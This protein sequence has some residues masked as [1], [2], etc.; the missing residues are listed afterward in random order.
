MTDQGNQGNQ[1]LEAASQDTDKYEDA[2]SFVYWSGKPG[3]DYL[4]G[5]ELPSGTNGDLECE[6]WRFKGDMGAKQESLKENT[7]LILCKMIFSESSIPKV[8]PSD[9]K[10]G[11]GI[12]G[13]YDASE[14]GAGYGMYLWKPDSLPADVVRL[15]WT[16]INKNAKDH[17]KTLSHTKDFKIGGGE[18]DPVKEMRQIACAEYGAFQV[19]LCQHGKLLLDWILTEQKKQ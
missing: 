4:H 12:F 16:T 15:E 3:F 18:V 11:I 17:T 2:R 7:T 10:A 8:N 13:V 5:L 19:E 9:E 14:R 1:A 6:K